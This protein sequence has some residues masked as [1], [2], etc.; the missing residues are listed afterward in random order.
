MNYGSMLAP[1]RAASAPEAGLQRVLTARGVGFGPAPRGSRHDLRRCLLLQRRRQFCLRR[2]VVRAAGSGGIRPI[3]DGRAR[4]RGHRVG[5]RFRMAAAV[6][7]PLFRPDGGSGV[8][9]PRRSTPPDR[10]GSWRCSTPGSASPVSLRADLRRHADRPRA[11][12]PLLAV[13]LSRSRLRRASGCGRAKD[14]GRS[15]SSIVCA[16]SSRFHRRRRRGLVHSRFHGHDWRSRGLPLCC[17]QLRSASRC[18]RRAPT[19]KQA[20]TRH[21]LRFFIY[22]KPIVLS[23]VLYQLVI[24]VNRQAALLGLGA[25]ATGQLSLA[26]DLGQRLFFAL[27]TLPEFLLFQYAL[28]REREEGRRF[29]RT[30]SFVQRHRHARSADTADGRICRDDPD[31]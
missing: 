23:L 28:K 6:V 9:S 13:A 7:D 17:R 22:A 5:G 10:A 16:K 19:I 30:A 11:L 25:E 2:T 29:G 8:G 14:R 12:T 3:C 24:V 27:N 15:R 18:A 21:A 26:T 20:S 1:H 31:L 4:S